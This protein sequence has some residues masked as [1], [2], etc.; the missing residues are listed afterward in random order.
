MLKLK[1]PENRPMTALQKWF[2]STRPFVGHGSKL[3]GKE[4]DFVSLKPSAERDA[5]T[6]MVEDVVGWVKLVRTRPF[7]DE[8]QWLTL[9]GSEPKQPVT[10]HGPCTS[11]NARCRNCQLWWGLWELW[12][13]WRWQLSCSTLSTATGSDLESWRSLQ[14]CLQ[15]WSVYSATPGGR[16]CLGHVQHMRQY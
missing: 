16:R 6:K 5:L 15:Q 13:S 12:C 8:R 2:E 11:R 10:L 14:C 9:G 1:P 7:E 4:T 3:M